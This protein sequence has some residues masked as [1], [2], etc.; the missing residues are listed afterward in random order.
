MGKSRIGPPI[1]IRLT[2]E[3]LELAKKQAETA[4]KP[5]RTLLREIIE[6]V[7]KEAAK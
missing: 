3:G 4:G 5:L 2:D 1:V 7:L 6:D